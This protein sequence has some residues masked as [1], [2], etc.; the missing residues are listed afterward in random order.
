MIQYA[1]CGKDHC[2]SQQNLPLVI[3]EFT[4]SIRHARLF[5]IFIQRF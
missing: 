1:N 3:I 4:D 2:E 5:V